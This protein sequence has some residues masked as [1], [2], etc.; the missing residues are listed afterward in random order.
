MGRNL[1][2]LNVMWKYM[3]QVKDSCATDMLWYRYSISNMIT[4]SCRNCFD[5][6][7]VLQKNRG[8][9]FLSDSKRKRKKKK[10]KKKKKIRKGKKEQEK[11]KSRGLVSVLKHYSLM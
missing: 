4:S 8:F 9:I 7:K 3:E 11:G 1:L 2:A 6:L 10:K 5:M